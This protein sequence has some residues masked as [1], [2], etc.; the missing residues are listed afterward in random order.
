MQSFRRWVLALM[1]FLPLFITCLPLMI[2]IGINVDSWPWYTYPMILA[3]TLAVMWG[4]YIADTILKTRNKF[5]RQILDLKLDPPNRFDRDS[6]REWWGHIEP[7]FA[8]KIAG[9]ILQLNHA[10]K[11]TEYLGGLSQSSIISPGDLQRI[12]NLGRSA[13]SLV[14]HHKFYTQ[15]EEFTKGSIGKT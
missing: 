15:M 6:I 13:T 8:A 2:V 7:Q 14:Q 1:I 11:V 9:M 12:T 10:Y 3:C 4:L 5:E